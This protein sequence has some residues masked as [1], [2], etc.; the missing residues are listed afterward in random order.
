MLLSKNVVAGFAYL[1]EL[2]ILDILGISYNKLKYVDDINA[3]YAQLT[4]KEDFPLTK[5]EKD[6]SEA[7]SKI[8]KYG[9]IDYGILFKYG[10][11]LSTLAGKLL[12]L[13]N[14]YIHEIYNNMPLK[15]S[16]ELVI[17]GDEIQEL[18]EI[19]PSKII[20]DI[21]EELIILILNGKLNNEKTQLTQYIL[22]NKG[23]WAN[24]L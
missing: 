4:F 20:K 10:L 12:D 24:E 15:S 5:E 13:D 1:K 19:K 7:I 2:Q 8:V 16:Q 17:D 23:K 14:K 18:L 11:Y 3:M 9:R 6:N 22:Q 21:Q